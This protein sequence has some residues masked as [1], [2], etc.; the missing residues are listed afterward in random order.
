[1]KGKKCMQRDVVQYLIAE[2]MYDLG[3]SSLNE[4]SEIFKYIILPT[5]LFI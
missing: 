5:A 3:V 4:C 2:K 1:M